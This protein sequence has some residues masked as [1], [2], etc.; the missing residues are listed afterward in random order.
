[1]ANIGATPSSIDLT[2]L[3]G[4]VQN[5]V[6]T[7]A[8]LASADTEVSIIFPSGTKRFTIHSDSDKKFRFY[9]VAGDDSDA[10]SVYPGFTYEEQ[11]LN[12]T[13]SGLILYVQSFYD[14]NDLRIRYWT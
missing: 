8:S 3:P 7:T 4:S 14:L 11:S 6:Q 5:P 13:G 1:M 2:G 10:E 9:F 12:I